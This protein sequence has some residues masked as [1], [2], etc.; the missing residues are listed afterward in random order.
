MN[1][2]PRQAEVVHLISEGLSDKEIAQ[3]MGISYWTVHAMMDLIRARTGMNR[4][5]LA[6]AHV[7]GELKARAAGA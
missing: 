5:Q 2:S 1:L 4:I 7:R 3:R 6:V